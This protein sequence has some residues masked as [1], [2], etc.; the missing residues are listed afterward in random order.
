MRTNGGAKLIIARNTSLTSEEDKK[1]RAY[2]YQRKQPLFV[3]RIQPS[4]VVKN[5]NLGIPKEF[6]NRYLDKKRPFSLTFNV[7]IDASKTWP[8]L[9]DADYTHVKF[10]KGWKDFA[11]KNKLKV[12]D[13]C[14]FE[15]IRKHKFQV[16]IIRV[17]DEKNAENLVFKTEEEIHYP[18]ITKACRESPPKKRRTNDHTKPCSS[19]KGMQTSMDN[20][21]IIAHKRNWK[22]TPE[23]YK[24]VRA[25]AH[26]CKHP[27]FVIKMQ[28]SFVEYNFSV[29]V[30]KTFRKRYFTYLDKKQY[31]SHRFNLR[32]D[33]GKTWPVTMFASNTHAKLKTGWKSFALDNKLNV[34]DTCIFE[35]INQ[36]EFKVSILRVAN[37]KGNHENPV[38]SEV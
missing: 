26:Q 34:D 37:A 28:P 17:S 8:V 24:R 7:Q 13:I 38:K 33:S 23:E 35:L 31:F 3:I 36:Q 29:G 4:F 15:L 30:P 11:L 1:V 2:A 12:G 10:R 25:Y 14:I 21:L 20:K 27:V 9:V 32:T 16:H 19:V 18:L 5:F 22:L 6:A